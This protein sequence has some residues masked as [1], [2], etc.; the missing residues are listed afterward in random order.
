MAINMDEPQPETKNNI[1]RIHE[2]AVRIIYRDKKSTF[3]ELLEKDNS[4]TT[5]V[6]NL[7]VLVTEMYNVQ[8]NCS[9]EIMTK[10]FPTN[11]AICEYDL[12][13]TSDFAARRI[14]TVRYGSE[15]LSYLGPRLWNIL[16]DEY[17]NLQ[18][19]KDFK[20]KIRSWVPENCR[21]LCKIYIHHIG[22]I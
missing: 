15:S 7:H 18:S 12:R 17:K 11:E 9:P 22:F 6:K 13:N 2:K 1:N 16:P 21:R 8:N 4:V 10:V 20:A 5:H 3:K 14:K 19:V